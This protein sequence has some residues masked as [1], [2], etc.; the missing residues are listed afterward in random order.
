MKNIFFY[1]NIFNITIPKTNQIVK[2]ILQNIIVNDLI[3]LVRKYVWEM[4]YFFSKMMVNYIYIIY[5]KEDTPLLKKFISS[6]H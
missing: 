5:L 6:F 4:S 2:N 1:E 3:R